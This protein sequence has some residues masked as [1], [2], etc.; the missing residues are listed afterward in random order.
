MDN[1]SDT[2]I[3]GYPFTTIIS[4]L[5]SLL[6]LNIQLKTRQDNYHKYFNIFIVSFNMVFINNKMPFVIWYKSHTDIKFT[7]TQ[8]LILYINRH[9]V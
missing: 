5:L 2:I 1:G 9:C 8:M 6:K 7:H 4:N 3:F